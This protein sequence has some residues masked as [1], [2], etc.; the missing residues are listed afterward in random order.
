MK[1]EINSDHRHAAIILILTELYTKD[2]TDHLDYCNPSLGCWFFND[3]S[4]YDELTE[5][6]KE[7]LFGRAAKQLK[8]LNLIDYSDMCKHSCEIKY[9]RLT[10]QGELIM[11][12]LFKN[13]SLNNF[14]Q[15]NPI[16]N[17]ITKKIIL[18]KI[19]EEGI[20][21]LV[22]ILSNGLKKCYSELINII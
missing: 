21:V 5:N 10:G 20:E 7:I 12:N 9:P 13:E 16:E 11:A 1:I 6:Q 18:E 3:Y 4:N 14:F 22:K 2:Y 15:K 17:G 19:K 8:D